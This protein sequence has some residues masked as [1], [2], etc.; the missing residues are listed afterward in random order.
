[1]IHEQSS[2]RS[3]EHAEMQRQR[4]LDAAE[5]AFIEYG[6]HAASMGRI[7]E[8]AGISQGLTYRYFE[9]KSAIILAI[10]E[11]QLEER[12]E[13]I[14]T[15]QSKSQFVDRVTELFKSW[16]YCDQRTMNP[17]LFL[18]M[19]AEASRSPEIAQAIQKAERITRDDF[20]EWLIRMAASLG[21]TMSEREAEQR[22][23]MLQVIFEGLAV[24]AV[25]DPDIDC[26][27]LRQAAELFLPSLLGLD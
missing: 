18:E 11:R 24:R 8:K 1:M 15:L 3:I 21:R 23:L 2:S 14:R 13:N 17:V 5:Q 19:S 7:A 26:N 27:S 10:I 22:C 20:K 16:L 12:R 4:I 9:N 6:F 25:R